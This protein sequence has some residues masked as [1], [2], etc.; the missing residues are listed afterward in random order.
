MEANFSKLKKEIAINIQKTI[1]SKCI[2]P[3]KKILLPHD[4]QNTKSTEQRKNIKR[5]EGKKSSNK[6]GR[7]VIYT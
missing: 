4:N 1:N 3:G 2:E 5:C 6:K 7:L